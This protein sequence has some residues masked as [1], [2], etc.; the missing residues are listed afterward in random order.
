M[1]IKLGKRA[2]AFEQPGLFA[3]LRFVPIAGFFRYAFCPGAFLHP[4]VRWHRKTAPDA[5]RMLAQ[6]PFQNGFLSREGFEGAFL[7]F[8]QIGGHSGNRLKQGHFDVCAGRAAESAPCGRQGGFRQPPRKGGL[9]RRPLF[10]PLCLWHTGPC[11]VAFG[12]AKGENDTGLR[13]YAAHLAGH[14]RKADSST[15]KELEIL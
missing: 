1:E 2:P 14:R 5:A 6:N 11:A 3:P 15:Q 7:F 9:L 13:P 12:K 10:L 4:W 8:M